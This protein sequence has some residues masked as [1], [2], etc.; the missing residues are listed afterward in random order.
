MLASLFTDFERRY[1]LLLLLC[2][3]RT[4]GDLGHRNRLHIEDCVRRCWVVSYRVLVV[5]PRLAIEFRHYDLAV[6]L[7]QL[8]VIDAFLVGQ[9]VVGDS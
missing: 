1:P 4:L 7:D 9:D 8:A 6:V 2:Y 5:V 3:Q